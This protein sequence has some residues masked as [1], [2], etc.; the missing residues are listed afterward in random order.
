[1]EN[2]ASA[3]SLAVRL[4]AGK[5]PVAPGGGLETEILDNGLWRTVYFQL[6]ILWMLSPVFWQ[7]GKWRPVVGQVGGGQEARA[8]RWRGAR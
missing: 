7:R 8:E 6:P 4:L 5:A 1:V 2:L 3:G